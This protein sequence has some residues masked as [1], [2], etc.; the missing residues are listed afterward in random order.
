M[1]KL[2]ITFII[3]YFTG[4]LSI[5]FAMSGYDGRKDESREN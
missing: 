4:I 2:F 5:A 3:G 1:I